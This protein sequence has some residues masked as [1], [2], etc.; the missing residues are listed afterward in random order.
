MFDGYY[1]ILAIHYDAFSKLYNFIHT[2][3]QVN[4]WRVS[5]ARI[6]TILAVA[7]PASQL[8]TQTPTGRDEP[9]AAT[10]GFRLSGHI[11]Y[12]IY[13]IKINYLRNVLCQTIGCY[14]KQGRR[15]AAPPNT[16]FCSGKAPI[17]GHTVYLYTC[18]YRWLSVDTPHVLREGVP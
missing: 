11:K 18:T 9:S 8:F 1:E 7:S 3:Y 12:M 5:S 15:A 2:V 6:F 17:R 10:K 4:S 13:R 14:E 16:P